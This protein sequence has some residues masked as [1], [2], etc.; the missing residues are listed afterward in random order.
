MLMAQGNLTQQLLLGIVKLTGAQGFGPDDVQFLS[1]QTLDP[2]VEA[3]VSAEVHIEHPRVLVHHVVGL[4]VVR[5]SVLLS[6]VEVQPAIHGWTAQQVG[7]HRHRQ[8]V[9]A[10]APRRHASCD[11]VNLVDALGQRLR[12]HARR[13]WRDAADIG[14]LGP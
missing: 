4:D 12:K 10:V 5:H 8:L 2:L 7:Q 3:P 13:L 11:V 14:R 6:N 1:D 9:L